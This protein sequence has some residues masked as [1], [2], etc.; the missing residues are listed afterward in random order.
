MAQVPN[1]DVEFDG[2]GVTAIFDFDFPY[3]KQ[4]EVFVTVDE[5]PV[6]YVWVAGSTHS[7]QVLPAPA[8]G[9]KVRIYRST[10]AY[11]PLHVF[12]AGVPFLPRYVDD[13]NRQLLY[14][15]QEAV[16]TAQDAAAT[17]ERIAT[18]AHAAFQTASDALLVAEAASTA[19]NG[20]TSTANAALAAATQATGDASN[21][22]A[23]ANAVDNKAQGA[24]DTAG[25]AST[26]AAA[27]LSTANAVDG[28]AQSALD[29]ANAATVAVAA[30][31][32][33]ANAADSKAQSALA[34]ANAAT[35]T[36][37]TA[38]ATAHAAAPKQ[39]VSDWRTLGPNVT[40][41][42]VHALNSRPFITKWEARMKVAF[43]GYAA[44]DILTITPQPE[45]AYT[46]GLTVYAESNTQFLVQTSSSVNA[47][48]ILGKGTGAETRL[49]WTACD[50]RC[51]VTA[52]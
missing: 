15:V 32:S 50:I 21:A 35:S 51:V 27:A 20:V 19:A 23:V 24:L 38:L 18:V 12:A 3:Q 30:A 7:V 5:V 25:T 48:V 1:V 26:A 46:V 45:V 11:D 44:G 52:L 10:L 14:V 13:N 36:A 22:L 17:A 47:A 2:D 31:T 43:A 29:T 16:D 41:T 28:K 39:W 33:T 8:L 4:A 9:T 40:S 49:A 37:N 42:F 6:T 34:N